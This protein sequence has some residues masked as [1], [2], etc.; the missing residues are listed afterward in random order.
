MRNNY[1]E[2]QNIPSGVPL[3]SLIVLIFINDLLNDEKWKI[4][5]F[6]DDTKQLGRYLKIKT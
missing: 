4:K 1:S 3:G 2:T 6:T 5:L